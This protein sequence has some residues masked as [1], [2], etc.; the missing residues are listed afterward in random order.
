MSPLVPRPRYN[1]GGNGG[2]APLPRGL[3]PGTAGA[4]AGMPAAHLPGARTS[5]PA[6]GAPERNAQEDADEGADTPGARFTR[7]ARAATMRRH[8]NAAS[9][10]R[11]P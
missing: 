6:S 9:D 3:R 10:G 11:T 8:A 1:P 7:A 4:L 5:P 2:Q